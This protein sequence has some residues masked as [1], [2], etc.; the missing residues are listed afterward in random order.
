MAAQA[1]GGAGGNPLAIHNI[2]AASA[3]VGLLGREGD[4]LRKTII[5]TTYYCL[6][7]GSIAYVF[8][9]GLGLNLGR[10]MLVLLLAALAALV[11]WMKR[12]RTVSTL[13]KAERL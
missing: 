12:Q 2:V 13:V 10:I 7:A 8:I 5:I 1:V 11:G 3:T 9:H 6:A 4:L